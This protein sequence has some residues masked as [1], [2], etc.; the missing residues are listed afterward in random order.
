MSTSNGIVGRLPAKELD[1]LNPTLEEA[2][3]LLNPGEFLD[4]KLIKLV[5]EKRKL[6]F[7]KK[8]L[9]KNLT[10]ERILAL[11]TNKAINGEVVSVLDYGCF[12]KLH[13]YGIEALLHRTEIPEGRIFEKG[14]CIDVFI[15]EV[16]TSK[17][18]VSLSLRES[19]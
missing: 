4:V 5:H 9:E 14:N 11:D 16:D 19:S 7:S 12:I 13:P 3:I 17:N 10:S 1:W 15:K 6:T 8:A 2:Q 18:R